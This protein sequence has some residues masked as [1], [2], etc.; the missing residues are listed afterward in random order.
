MCFHHSYSCNNLLARSVAETQ[1][2]CGQYTTACF[3]QGEQYSEHV[4]ITVH[5]CTMHLNGVHCSTQYAGAVHMCA[6][7]YTGLQCST[8]MNSAVHMCTLQYTGVQLCT[9]TN[10]LL[11]MMGVQVHDEIQYS[12]GQFC[13]CLETHFCLQYYFCL[14]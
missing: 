5:R 7:K 10:T 13:F 11:Q 3:Y 4:Y 14:Q 9:K 1:L 8:W 2:R 6:L 12:I